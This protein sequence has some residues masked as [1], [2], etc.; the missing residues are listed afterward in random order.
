METYDF[1]FVRIKFYCFTEYF[2]DTVCQF[3]I[4][5]CI[6]ATVYWL[7]IFNIIW[8]IILIYFYNMSSVT[9]FKHTC[10]GSYF[11]IMYNIIY[12]YILHILYF[13][14][15]IFAYIYIFCVNI[16]LI[17]YFNLFYNMSSVTQFKHTC[18]GY[19]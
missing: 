13:T 8:Y 12:L 2:I 11:I 10:S 14:Y 6:I 5:A 7:I 3:V 4:C 18:S 9:Q 19:K 15:F 17:Y 16:H 1:N